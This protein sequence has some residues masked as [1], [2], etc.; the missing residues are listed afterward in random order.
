MPRDYKRA[1]GAMKRV[2]ELGLSGEEAIM[3]AFEENKKDLSRA[4]GN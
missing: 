1:L 4:G 3:A 2:Q